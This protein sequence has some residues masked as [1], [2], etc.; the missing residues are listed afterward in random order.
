M[1]KIPNSASKKT[2]RLR[3]INVNAR[4]VAN[5]A[6]QLE[7]ALLQ[8]DPHVTI[9]TETWLHQDITDD[10]VFPPSYKVFRK[11]RQSRGGG[12]AVLVKEQFQA[13]VLEDIVDLECI[14][15]KLTCWGKCLILYALYRPP[16]VS[17]DYLQQLETHMSRHTNNKVF[18]IGDFN[19]PGLNW[20]NLHPCT[21]GNNHVNYLCNIMLSHDLVQLVKEPTREQGKSSSILDLVFL[22]RSFH[23]FSLSIEEGLS[24]HYL[25][26]MEI[27]IDSPADRSQQD[28]RCFKDFSRSNDASV[29]EH[30]ETCVLSFDNPDACV[31]WDQFKAICH[32][33]IDKFVPTK[34]K[35]V[36][37][38]TP[39]MTREII[40]MKRKIKRLKK[41]RTASEV[42]RKLK[43]DLAS[44]VKRSKDYYFNVSLPNFIR[45]DPTKFWNYI[46]EK[47][48]PISEIKIRDEIVTDQRA[49]AH[50][51]NDY[52]HSVY[53]C[54]QPC[55][56][57]AA[58]THSSDADFISY[59]GIVS[60]L[61]NLKTK[62]SSGPDDIPNVFLR[63]YAESLAKFLVI[64][65]RISF[66]TGKVPSDWKIARVVPIYKKG[67]RF[68]IE[69]YRPISLLSTCS[70]IMEHII[71]NHINDF[72]Q[73]NSV[74]T[75]HQHGFRKGYSTSTQLVSVIHSFASVLDCNGQI[76]AIFLDFSKAFD[77]VPHHSLI[78]KLR[79]IGLSN[80]I[81]SWIAD[82]LCNRKQFVS[83]GNEKSHFL[84]VRSGV[85]QGSVLGPLL[86]LLFVNDIVYEAC[87]G[88]EM[89]LFADDC[90]LFCNISS[91][92]DQENLSKSLGRIGDWCSRWGMVL[93]TE[94]SVI[95]RI[96]RKKA[97]LSFNYKLGSSPLKEVTSVKYLGLTLTN[98]LSWN[99]HIDNVCSSAFRKL[100]FLRH[101]LKAAP[102]NVKL[103]SYYSLIRPK[104]EYACIIWDPFTS[105]NI[106]K[107]E[108]IQRKATRFIYS[109][110]SPYDSPSDL[111][112]DNNIPL[113]Q[114][115]RKKLRL[116]FL[117]LVVNRKLGLDPSNYLIPLSR[118]S[119]RHFYPGMFTPYFART[120]L[121]KFSF[122]PQTINDWN[123]D[124]QS[125]CVNS[126]T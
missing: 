70:K 54:S 55:N 72:L 111:L 80:V 112:R 6:E 97:P 57:T 52:F 11:D 58:T 33:C 32:F 10:V 16:D 4:S 14:C 18:L 121:F 120:D 47:K 29:I 12:V 26:N 27:N 108:K 68:S 38:N 22:P 126:L 28:V 34:P 45:S 39:W 3:I 89:R 81:V 24:D 51:F 7:I 79:N 88:V 20:D 83:L 93:N 1:F 71:A 75:G 86:F 78:I 105:S 94:K 49:I 117:S 35:K 48:K 87:P 36:H 31:L 61:L 40:Q 116:D 77:K 43:K 46:S 92:S 76:D 23:D 95:M 115:R 25:V 73:R 53:S 37:K 8:Y 74:L 125:R 69:N 5:K 2:K 104:L 122:F 84:P 64:I 100:C 110:F 65:F 59:H 114:A 96:T 101:K 15:L 113:L 66:L 21:T 60:M 85:P 119:T 17:P 42:T 50:H 41:A 13:Y 56:P 98:T 118:R 106:S 82:Y 19:L 124:I 103:L 91:P 9:L 90:V 123:A 44:A 107:L 63:R 109:K 102:S 30:L 62:T 99:E 67:C